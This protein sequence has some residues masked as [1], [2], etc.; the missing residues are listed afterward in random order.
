VVCL[1]EGQPVLDAAGEP[2]F[3]THAT[4]TD[5][6]ASLLG[7]DLDT[8]H[9]QALKDIARLGDGSPLQ[10]FA[11]MVAGDHMQ[12]PLAVFEK[13]SAE[14]SEPLRRKLPGISAR[15]NQTRLLQAMAV[16]KL[17]EYLLLS[18]VRL[19]DVDPRF[20]TK[21]LNAIVL[22]QLKKLWARANLA[23]E[24]R[25]AQSYDPDAEAAE[26]RPREAMLTMEQRTMYNAVAQSCDDRAKHNGMGPSD[27]RVFMFDAHAGTGK[28]FVLQTL[29]QLER[30]KARVAMV[31]AT[32]G[33]AALLLDGS[34]P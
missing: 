22:H 1:N 32:A 19:D 16:L 33:V 11:A 9:I 4:Y 12:D 15:T 26:A 30:S 28:T 5:A 29:I 7:S 6:L 20:R 13:C 23:P 18:N 17:E 2:T 31:S 34:T 24:L 3:K 8:Y 27:G 14:L 21:H 10:T 25:A